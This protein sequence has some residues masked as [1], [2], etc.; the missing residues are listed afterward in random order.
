MFC[1]A[2]RANEIAGIPLSTYLEP[3]DFY[4]EVHYEE[5]NGREMKFTLPVVA[6]EKE[7]ISE[8]LY[9]NA[10]NTAIKTDNSP[11]RAAQIDRLNEIYEE[12]GYYLRSGRIYSQERRAPCCAHCTEHY[13]CLRKGR[14]NG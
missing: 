14:G 10:T 6:V 1:G 2:I 8:T 5:A 13:L 11:Q 3:G 7:F 4:L 12:F 9:L